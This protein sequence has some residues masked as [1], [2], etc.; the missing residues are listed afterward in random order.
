MDLLFIPLPCHRLPPQKRHWKQHKH[1]CQE[2]AAANNED[3]PENGA[4]VAGGAAGSTS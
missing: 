4:D 2:L 3:V 1:L